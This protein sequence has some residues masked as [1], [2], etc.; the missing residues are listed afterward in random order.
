[1][2]TAALRRPV[3]PRFFSGGSYEG[4]GDFRFRVS[5]MGSVSSV[6]L[7]GVLGFRVWGAQGLPVWGLCGVEG[8]GLIGF[9]A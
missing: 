4:F 2:F 9:R 8:L 3:G 5:Y 6:F 1:M 7:K